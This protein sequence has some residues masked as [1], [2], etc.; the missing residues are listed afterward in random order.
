MLLL[1]PV[2]YAALAS[3]FFTS[4]TLIPQA[5]TSQQ[6]ATGSL[7]TPQLVSHLTTAIASLKSLR[8]TVDARE[9]INT[10]YITAL[11]S[12][13]LTT[14]PLRIYLK[15]QKGIEV[16]YVTGQN[17]GDAWVYP[18]AFPYVTLSL[19]PM[20]ALMRRDQH[21]TTLQVGFGTIAELLEG[22]EKLQDKAFN[23]SFKYTGDSTFQRRPCYVLRSDYPQFRYITYKVGKDE[24][25][26]TIAARFGCGEYR[27]ME[28]NSLTTSSQL[29]EGQTL[30]VPNA[31]GKRTFVLVDPKSSLPLAIAVYDDRGLY[32]RYE[33]SNVIANQVIP[34]EEFTKDYKGYKL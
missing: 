17:G 24:S 26:A 18:G 33:F 6:P 16:L 10:K 23:R 5:L 19:D 32:E 21:H 25:L 1:F 27:I 34:A 9:R 3:L 29:T 2:P 30:Q 11:S 15:N 22:S 14:K 12:I 7:T 13:K 31:Y 28:R 20:G 8:A 4:A